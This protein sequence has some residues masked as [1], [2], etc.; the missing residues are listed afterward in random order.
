MPLENP[1]NILK[2]IQKKKNDVTI[3]IQKHKKVTIVILHVA[4]TLSV[5]YYIGGLLVFWRKLDLDVTDTAAL[6][7]AGEILVLVFY[8][9]ERN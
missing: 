7:G 6:L 2:F 3:F 1:T 4:L 9:T 5:S 8:I